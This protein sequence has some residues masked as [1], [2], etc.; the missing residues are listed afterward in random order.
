MASTPIPFLN[1][2]QKQGRGFRLHTAQVRFPGSWS[3]IF[4]AYG[5][6]AGIRG[7]LGRLGP[8]SWMFSLW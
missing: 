1:L 2:L 8:W 7:W 5:E 4:V 6:A 3:E